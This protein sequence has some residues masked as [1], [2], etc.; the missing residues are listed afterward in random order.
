MKERAIIADHFAP[1]TTGEP[2]S[3]NLTDDAAVL[4]PP[5]GKQIAITTDSVIQGVHVLPD[6]TPQQY[7][8]KLMRRN[9]SDLAA[10]GATPW[11]YLI[12]VR[13]PRDVDKTWFA[14]FSDALRA[15]Q[16][17][18]KLVLAGGDTTIGGDTIHLTLTALGLI[19]SAP[20]TRSGAREGDMLY[21][22]GAIG[23]AALGLAMLQADADAGGPWTDRYHTPLPRLAV[24]NGLRNLAT[25]ALDCSDGLLKDVARL[26][27]AGNVGV[28]IALDAVPVSS[29][30]RA[31][32]DAAEGYEARSAIWQTIL[33]GG[34]DYELIF[35]APASA[36]ASLQE[37]ARFV[38]VPL[39]PIGRITR[40]RRMHFRDEAGAHAFSIDSGW[41]Y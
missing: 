4:T 27:E 19:D 28:E 40:E 10:M 3:F 38:G 16:E 17:Q 31:L 20:L 21:V 26:C 12:N 37:M 39:T 36:Q 2:G 22:S 5:V 23:D 34:D 33:T 32:L 1:L 6:A 30:T 29:S 25:A 18:F 9:L 41:D 13:V 24:G 11:R 8:V 15:E 14:Q 35:T 7:A